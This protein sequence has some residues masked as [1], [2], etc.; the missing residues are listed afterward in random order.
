MRLLFAAFGMCMIIQ[1]VEAQ[2]SVSLRNVSYP[3]GIR[4][5]SETKWGLTPRFRGIW[6]M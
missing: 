6:T 4:V 1:S 5:S 2:N 3:L